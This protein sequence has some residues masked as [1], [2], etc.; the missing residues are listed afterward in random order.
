M[1]R[2][3]S[4]AQAGMELSGHPQCVGGGRTPKNT[5]SAQWPKLGWSMV[6]SVQWQWRAWYLGF[7]L[8]LLC[9][10]FLYFH[11][12][13]LLYL[14]HYVLSIFL[15]QTSSKCFQSIQ[16]GTETAMT[17]VIWYQMLPHW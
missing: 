5:G 4:A 17:P 6:S 15:S 13:G 10:Y 9:Q 8:P 11:I 1:H 2:L 12:A 3:D 14:A 16:S 7:Q